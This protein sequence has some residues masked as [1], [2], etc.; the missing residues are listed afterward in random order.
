MAKDNNISNM[1]R[2]GMENTIEYEHSFAAQAVLTP[3]GIK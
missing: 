2:N 1:K 3:L